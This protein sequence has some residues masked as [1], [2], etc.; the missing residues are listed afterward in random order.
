MKTRY[1]VKTLLEFD[2]NTGRSRII[3][4]FSQSAA[5]YGTTKTKKIKVESGAKAGEVVTI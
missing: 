2:S 4:S 3:Q 1:W 5:G